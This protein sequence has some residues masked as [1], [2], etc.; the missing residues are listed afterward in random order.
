MFS[1]LYKFQM[2]NFL[3]RNSLLYLLCSYLVRDDF[4]LS[5]RHVL[6]MIDIFLKKRTF[7]YYDYNS[8]RSRTTSHHSQSTNTS[9]SSSNLYPSNS[10][11]TSKEKYSPLPTRAKWTKFSVLLVFYFIRSFSLYRSLFFFIQYY[12]C[13]NMFYF[14]V[15]YFFVGASSISFLYYFS[16]IILS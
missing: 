16:M 10:D 3:K 5:I 9:S 12:A 4:S 11:Q 14:V 7:F 2:L 13:V 15:F 8:F 1:F 6:K